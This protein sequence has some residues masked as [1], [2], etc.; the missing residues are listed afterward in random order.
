MSRYQAGTKKQQDRLTVSGLLVIIM[1]VRK[2]VWVCLGVL[3][4]LRIIL[5]LC[6]VGTFKISIGLVMETDGKSNVINALGAYGDIFNWILAKN[7]VSL[8]S[9]EIVGFNYSFKN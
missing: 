9:L 5:L 8:I 7:A 6:S 2:L 1:A 4:K 3:I